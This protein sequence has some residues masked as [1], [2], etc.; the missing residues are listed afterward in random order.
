MYESNYSFMKF[1]NLVNVANISK[2]PNDRTI[3]K[4]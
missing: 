2:V 4:V 3:F 1:F